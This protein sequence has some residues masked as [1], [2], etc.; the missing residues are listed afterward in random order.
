MIMRLLSAA[1][2]NSVWTRGGGTRHFWG[3]I[4]AVFNRVDYERIK[5]IG[6]DRAAAEW[7]LRCGAKVR[8]L[9]FER[10]HHDYNALPTG[11]LD[12]YKIQGID[13]TESCIMYRGFDHLAVLCSSL[14]W[15]AAP[16]G[17]E[18]HP[19]RLHRGRLPGEAELHRGP[20]EHPEQPGGGVL[21]ERLRQGAHRPAQAGEPATAG[22]Q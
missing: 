21:R 7:L 10:W 22:P 14:R 13:A 8:F 11:P 3:W 1:L 17:G 19:V 6:P 5:A 2:R 16:G 15:P 20:A 9:G 4:N 18:A 12:R